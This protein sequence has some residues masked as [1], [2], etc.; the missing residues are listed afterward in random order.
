[1]PAVILGLLEEDPD[2]RDAFERIT[3]LKYFAEPK[4]GGPF[5]RPP[6]PPHP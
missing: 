5:S 4:S 2:L 3:I 1:V 6:L